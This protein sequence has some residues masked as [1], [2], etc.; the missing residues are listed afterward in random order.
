V[1]PLRRWGRIVPF[2][3]L[4]LDYR[5]ESRIVAV[6]AQRIA[7]DPKATAIPLR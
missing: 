1:A 3:T 4:A 6:P 5:D 2:T 7:A